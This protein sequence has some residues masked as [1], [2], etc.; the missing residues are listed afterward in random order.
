MLFYLIYRKV[1]YLSEIKMMKMTNS[2]TRIVN[3]EIRVG[4]K[5]G[6]FRFKCLYKADFFKHVSL[7]NSFTFVPVMTN[8][9][10]FPPSTQISMA[11]S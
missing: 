8:I 3:L 10:F 2:Y 7:L 11:G 1:I 4:L 6:R 9:I 5:V